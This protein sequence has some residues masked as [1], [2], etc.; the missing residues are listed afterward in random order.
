[1]KRI[2][3]LITGLLLVLCNAKAQIGESEIEDFLS[4]NGYEIIDYAKGIPACMN[5]TVIYSNS[6]KT[7]GDEEAT[8]L[9]EATH[10]FT[11]KDGVMQGEL[12]V[13]WMTNKVFA[14]VTVKDDV[15]GFNYVMFFAENNYCYRLDLLDLSDP[16]LY[17]LNISKTSFSSSTF[18]NVVDIYLIG[19]SSKSNDI[20]K[21]DFSIFEKSLDCEGED[22]R[23]TDEDLDELM[24][25]YYL[26]TTEDDIRKFFDKNDYEVINY[27]AGVPECLNGY[28]IFTNS[29]KAE[30]EAVTKYEDIINVFSVKDGVMTCELDVPAMT[31]KILHTITAKNKS[32]NLESIMLLAENGYC[33]RFDVVDISSPKLFNMNISLTE[34]LSDSYSNLVEVYISKQDGESKDINKFDFSVFE[35]SLK[36]K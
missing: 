19:T 4:E 23:L 36:C 14:T 5:G 2:T 27:V 9:E 25:E 3:L 22:D 17:N 13:D 28:S 24:A 15:L 32:T 26:L 21:F 12:D 33:Y 34:F 31:N 16:V 7:A 30:G 20:S 8:T 29:M 18:T 10:F 11:I 1:M 6:L 35:K